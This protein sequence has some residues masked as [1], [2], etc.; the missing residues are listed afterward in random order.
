MLLPILVAAALAAGP[1]AL[2]APAPSSPVPVDTGKKTAGGVHSGRAGAI[3]VDI[4][5]IEAEAP[6]DGTLSAPPWQQAALLTGFSQYQPID[7]VPATDSTQVLV[8][9]SPTAI[10]FGIRAFEAHGAAHATLANRDKID[11][12]DNVALILTP[13]VHGRNA[14]VLAVNPFGIQEDGTIT[15]GVTASG[16]GATS[17]TGMPLIDLS[18]DFVFDSKGQ[19]TPF[20]YEVVI[21][22]PFRSLKYQ[23]ND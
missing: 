8:W 23:A 15:E 2:T 5:R 6:V 14:I 16:F 11:G 3:S 12:D 19:L 17:Q 21:R 10:Y 13:F 20:G 18:A 7:G 22:I 9:Y 4:P 1:G